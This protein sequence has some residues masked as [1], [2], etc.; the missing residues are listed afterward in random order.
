MTVC[1]S[2]FKSII[3]LDTTEMMLVKDIFK[4]IYDDVMK[5]ASLRQAE[6]GP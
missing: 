3:N 4:L 5:E 1:T 6:F 2:I